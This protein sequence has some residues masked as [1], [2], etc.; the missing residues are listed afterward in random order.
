MSWVKAVSRS[1]EDVFDENADE[2][3]LLTKEWTS[4]MKKRVRDGYVDGV[5]AG[6]EA[7]LQAGFNQGYKEGAAKTVAVGRLKGIVS[8][9]HCWY[10][11]QNPE[12][13]I[14]ASLTDLVQ[15]VS[16]YE[17]TVVNG[18]KHAMENPPPSVSSVSE[19][20]EDLEVNQA[21]SDCHGGGCTERSCCKGGEQM[22]LDNPCEV[23][24]AC[25]GSPGYLSLS[26]LLQCCM[27]L[28]SELRLPQD[29]LSHIEEL[30]SI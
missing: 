30:K 23:Q 21:Q 4:N 26:H 19:S 9:I 25:S 10:Q 3:N 22:D 14:P 8:A 1:E 27:D 29:L 12:S 16:Q 24:K 17:D 18:L 2:L 28:V 5:D 13:P 15:R 7:S 20:M 6:E 11:I